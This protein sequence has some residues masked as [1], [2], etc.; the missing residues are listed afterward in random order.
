LHAELLEGGRRNGQ[1]GLSVATVRLIA[2]IVGRM[3]EDAVGWDFLVSNPAKRAGRPSNRGQR[4]RVPEPWSPDELRTFLAGSAAHRLA[5]LWVFMART[6]VRRGE[7]CALAWADV[8]LTER[9]ARISRSLVSVDHRA[10]LSTTKTD[11]SRVVTLDDATVAALKAHRAAQA[12]L[13]LQVGGAGWRDLGYVF[14]APD[15]SPWHPEGRSVAL[16]SAR[17]APT[18]CATRSPRWPS[19]RAPTRRTSRRRSGTPTS[20]RRSGR[21]P[22][23]PRPAGTLSPMA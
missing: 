7:A 4:L 17:S 14:T 20:R 6:G 16:G 2:T 15:G 22:T 9:T 10:L 5:P 13:R 1:G 11:R 3:L 19:R 21:T 23:A 18:T 12:A 8:D